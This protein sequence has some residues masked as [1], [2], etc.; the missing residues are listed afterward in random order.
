MFKAVFKC[1]DAAPKLR[2]AVILSAAEAQLSTAQFLSQIPIVI[3]SIIWKLRSLY[4]TLVAIH[5]YVQ[6]PLSLRELENLRLLFPI[7]IGVS[8]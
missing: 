6:W 8:D 7:A 1:S 4:T 3:N 2:V 5:L